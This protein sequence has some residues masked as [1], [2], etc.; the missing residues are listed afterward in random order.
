MIESKDILKQLDKCA[1]EFSFPML[2]NGYVAPAGTEMSIYRDENRW[3]IIIEVIGFSYRGGG[4]NGISNCLHIF[5]NCLDYEPGMQNE[6]F[7]SLTDDAVNCQTFDDDEL[8]YLNPDCDSF[9]LR[10]EPYSIIH[11]REKY[12]LSGIE[13]ED[14]EKINAFEFLRLLN[15][16]HHDKLIASEDEIR[17]RIP[18]DIPLMLKVEE[19]FHPDLVNEDMPGENETFIQI[20]KVLETGNIEWYKPSKEANTHWSNWPDGGTL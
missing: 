6:N 20:A 14:E 5:G 18:V 19:W 12:K 4:H 15:D 1:Q 13:L 17:E 3:V 11:D 16:L 8:F 10:G 2:D 9:L 7:L